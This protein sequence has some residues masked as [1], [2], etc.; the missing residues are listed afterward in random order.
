MQNRMKFR[1]PRIFGDGMVLQRNTQVKIWG[2]TQG[3][4]DN[5]RVHQ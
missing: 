4:S 1:L 5:L 2:W 3:A